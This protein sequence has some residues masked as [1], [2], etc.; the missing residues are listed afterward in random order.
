MCVDKVRCEICHKEFSFISAA[1]VITHGIT[2]KEYKQKFPN[3]NFASKTYRE[4]QKRDST[5]RKYK[6]WEEKYSPEELEEKRNQFREKL[7]ARKIPK[8]SKLQKDF[9]EILK[10]HINNIVLS[11]K[12][13][14]YEID[15][16]IP[17]RKIAIEVDGNYFHNYENKPI[18]QLSVMQK[19]NIKNDKCKETY[20]KNKGWKLIRIWE[21]EITDDV[22]KA[23]NKILEECNKP[24]TSIK[25][26]YF[27][28]GR[29][30]TCLQ[31]NKNLTTKQVFQKNN[32]C[33]R[34]CIYEYR[35]KEKQKTVVCKECGKEF[36]TVLSGNKSFCDKYCQKLYEN[37]TA[38]E[39]MNKESI[40]EAIRNSDYNIKRRENGRIDVVCACGKEFWIHK[41]SLKNNKSGIFCCCRECYY[42]YHPRYNKE[43]KNESK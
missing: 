37:K 33:C 35:K 16:A 38:K 14:Y 4:G 17:E 1:H 11:Y 3:T 15:I 6:T 41:K 8:V 29:R 40:K 30:T 10:K 24:F 7:L 43:Q 39:R 5:G 34:S 36:I 2:W 31:C 23:V 18:E 42:K 28:D 13:K 32:F 12:E 22:T 25:Y 21:K 19:K 20:L 9:F 27:S 26:D